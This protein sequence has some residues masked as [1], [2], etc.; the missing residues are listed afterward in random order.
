MTKK[1]AKVA[2]FQEAT[3]RIFAYLEKSRQLERAL[4]LI[5][6]FDFGW[7]DRYTVDTEL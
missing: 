3:W 5:P 6:S 4:K 7:N 1:D 2:N